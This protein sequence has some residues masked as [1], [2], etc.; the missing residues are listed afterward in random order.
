MTFGAT[1][2]ECGSIFLN[3]IFGAAANERPSTVACDLHPG[4]ALFI[5]VGWWHHVESLDLTIGLS[6]TGFDRDN[7]FFTGYR[8][9]GEV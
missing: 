1:A 8:T 4:E 9:Y 5:P 2:I 7:D 3:V 6:F